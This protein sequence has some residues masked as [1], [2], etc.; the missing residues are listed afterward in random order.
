M[1]TFIS[2]ECIVAFYAVEL[3]FILYNFEAHNSVKCLAYILLSVVL[4]LLK[5]E[6]SKVGN[7]VV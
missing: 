4:C 5:I 1:E 3:F 7:H 6:F 2:V